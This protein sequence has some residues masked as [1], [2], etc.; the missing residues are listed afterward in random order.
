MESWEREWAR[1]G[2]LLPGAEVVEI[3][4]GSSTGGMRKY[5]FFYLEKKKNLP[6]MPGMPGPT[7][8]G[9]PVPG[10][11]RGGGMPGGCGFLRSRG[12]SHS[13]SRSRI[14]RS[15]S[16]PGP[17][18]LPARV[19]FCSDAMAGEGWEEEEG[20][21]CGWGGC[22]V[23]GCGRRSADAAGGGPDWYG[24]VPTGGD[25]WTRGGPVPGTAED[26]GGC[27]W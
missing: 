10:P 25:I 12:L 1:E 20:G 5:D 19:G 8:G 2:P 7:G 27:L 9:A 26:G 23:W 6:G 18:G 14:G 24:D 3:L 15:L 17:Q 13:R 11:A 4:W 16:A 22:G 21:A